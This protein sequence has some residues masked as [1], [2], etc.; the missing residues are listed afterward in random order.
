VSTCCCYTAAATHQ[1]LTP[2]AAA[3][4]RMHVLAVESTIKQ[5]HKS[6]QSCFAVRTRSKAA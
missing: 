1:A 4:L 6:F 2:A 3:T 5:L